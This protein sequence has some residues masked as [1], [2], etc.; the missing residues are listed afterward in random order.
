[1]SVYIYI[2][3]EENVCWKQ[4][5]HIADDGFAYS[6]SKDEARHVVRISLMIFATLHDLQVSDLVKRNELNGFC[7]QDRPRDSNEKINRFRDIARKVLVD[8]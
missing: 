8:L 2:Y 7:N 5:N 4:T 3:N 1:M 6:Q